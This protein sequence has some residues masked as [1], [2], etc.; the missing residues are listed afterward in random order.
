MAL[1]ARSARIIAMI[2]RETIGLVLAGLA[3]GSAL[4]Y[5][6]SR[7]IGSQLYGVVPED[8]FTLVVAVGVLLAAMS[9]AVYLPA[10]RALQLNPLAALRQE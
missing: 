9:A 5:G 6:A 3:A 10:R 4:A 2:L 7:W 8:P 1:G